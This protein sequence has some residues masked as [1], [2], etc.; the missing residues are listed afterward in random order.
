MHANRAPNR[1]RHKQ[2][3]WWINGESKNIPFNDKMS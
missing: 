1:N 2:T 3:K